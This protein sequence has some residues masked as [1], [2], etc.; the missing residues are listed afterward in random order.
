MLWVL[1]VMKNYDVSTIVTC[2]L[3]YI[4]QITL[5][6]STRCQAWRMVTITAQS[7]PGGVTSLAGPERCQRLRLRDQPLTPISGGTQ[8]VRAVGIAVRQLARG[9]RQLVTGEAS[10][11]SRLHTAYFFVGYPPAAATEPQDFTVRIRPTF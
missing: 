3:R 2:R 1:Y 11:R 4:W 8:P 7:A 10:E 9:G 6:Y 5:T